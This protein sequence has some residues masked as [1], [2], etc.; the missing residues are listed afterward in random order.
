M[1]I[2]RRIPYV[3]VVLSMLIAGQV[4][5][6]DFSFT[7]NLADDD[8]IAFFDFS[9]SSVSTITLRSW[10]YAGG[11]NA[12]GTD[13]PSGGFDPILAVFN[14]AT[15]ALIGENDDGSGVPSDPDTGSAYDTLL[16]IVDLPVGDYTA[17]VAQYSNFAIGPNLSD[18][19]DGSGQTNFE[20][21]TSLWA[22]DILNVD[23]AVG[24]PPASPP[25]P[26]T[27][28]PTTSQWALIMLSMLIGLMVFANRRRLF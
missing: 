18:G 11:I 5:A 10:S 20:G 26:A 19:F 28:I 15:G 16:E 13:I 6:E 12:A 25:P 8:D 22:F 21:R 7:G 9:V 3:F 1:R 27:P 4:V 2:Q 24:P 17:S 23:A 14:S